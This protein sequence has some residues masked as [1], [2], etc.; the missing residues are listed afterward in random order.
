MKGGFVSNVTNQTPVDVAPTD[1]PASFFHVGIVVEDIEQA[2]ARYS[3]VFGITFSEPE[4]AVIPYLAD[5][6]PAPGP[7]EQIVAFARTAP[8]FY[9]L[10]QAQESG[11]FSRANAGRVLYYGYWE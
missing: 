1:L 4:S 5:P 9:Q 3:E 7:V 8:P 6:D 10:I 2:I 11:V